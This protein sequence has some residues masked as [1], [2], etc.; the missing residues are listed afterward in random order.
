[1]GRP[2]YG[3]VLVPLYERDGLRMGELARQAHTGKQTMTELVRRLER[4]GL[5][6][7]RPDP[8]DVRAWLT[9]LTARSRQ[10]ATV[11]TVV[12]AELDR[13]ARRRLGRR[14]VAELKATLAELV[15]LG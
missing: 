13:L 1:M 5:V 9:F 3:L 8:S 14:E 11:A 15:D 7:R 2:S 10:V 4:D 6:E 12:L